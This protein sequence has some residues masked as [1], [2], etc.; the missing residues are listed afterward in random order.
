MFRRSL[1]IILC[2]TIAGCAA[3]A[4]DLRRAEAA[5]TA[6]RYE[7]TQAWL[8]NLERSTPQMDSDQRA[9]FFFMRGMTAYRL[10]DQAVARHYLALAQETAGEDSA[11]LRSD[12][13]QVLTRTMGELETQGPASTPVQAEQEPESSTE[14]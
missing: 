11:A 13:R 9:R 3:L 1:L 6:A 7:D 2:F 12:W 8:V 14:P 5:Y 4:D 10:G